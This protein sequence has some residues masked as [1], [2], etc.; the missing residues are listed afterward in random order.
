MQKETRNI[1]AQP[2]RNFLTILKFS[3]GFTA[4][5]Y[6]FRTATGKAVMGLPDGA[7][8][9]LVMAG[10]VALEQPGSALKLDADWIDTGL[11]GRSPGGTDRRWH[12]AV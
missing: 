12:I 9:A 4:A 2:S 8:R 6:I 10:G 5:T 7:R 11:Q 1:H 3:S